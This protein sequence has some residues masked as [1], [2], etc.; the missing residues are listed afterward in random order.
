MLVYRLNAIWS[1]CCVSVVRS[2]LACLVL[3][4]RVGEEFSCSRMCDVSLLVYGLGRWYLALSEQARFSGFGGASGSTGKRCKPSGDVEQQAT[5][6]CAG[7]RKRWAN[8]MSRRY[9][10]C[11]TWF[12]GQIYCVCNAA[13][14]WWRGDIRRQL[15]TVRTE[16]D[17]CVSQC[18]RMLLS[19]AAIAEEGT[20]F[21]APAL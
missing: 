17:C 18:T 21:W 9:R 5:F 19:C 16:P 20:L 14:Q 8:R 7:K 10:R 12:S 6:C 13:I 3:S 4:F 11:S 1:A 15:C 2:L